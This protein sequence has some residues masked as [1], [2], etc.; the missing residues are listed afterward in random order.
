ME[1]NRL[2]DNGIVPSAALSKEGNADGLLRHL[3]IHLN[4]FPWKIFNCKQYFLLPTKEKS[5]LFIYICQWLT[6]YTPRYR[7]LST[8]AKELTAATSVMQSS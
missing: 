5:S 4:W 7:G 2:T 8:L 6:I 1:T 3:R